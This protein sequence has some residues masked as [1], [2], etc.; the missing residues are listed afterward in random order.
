MNFKAFF[1]FLLCCIFII[2][3]ESEKKDSRSWK[4]GYDTRENVKTLITY[5]I[6]S[7]TL[8]EY[9]KAIHLLKE[10][11]HLYGN[12][13]NLSFEIN[14]AFDEIV[15]TQEVSS[16]VF[17]KLKSKIVKLDNLLLDLD[18]PEEIYEKLKDIKEDLEL[19]EELVVQ[20]EESDFEH[21]LLEAE[22]ADSEESSEPEKNT[23]SSSVVEKET[24]DVKTKLEIT[25]TETEIITESTEEP[26]LLE[27]AEPVPAEESSVP[28]IPPADSEPAPA[29]EP[30]SSE[31]AES[32]PAEE[33][34]VPEMPSADAESA[35]A[36]E[37]ASSEEAESAPAQ[38]EL[39]PADS[40][41][42]VFTGE[43]EEEYSFDQLS[44]EEQ[45]FFLFNM[46]NKVNTIAKQMG[47]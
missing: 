30:A 1:I 24:L 34:S 41:S 29:E 40:E 12:L 5:H 2:G 6:F 18:L 35:P 46:Q 42:S 8:K 39:V 32:A 43:S 13:I 44:K 9:K 17:K 38:T 7:K 25:I 19:I 11:R 10:E 47:Y 28:G 15:K 14:S 33:S 31:E 36:E 27:E 37:P 20:Y 3:C 26:A 22:P 16:E 21:D 4:E 23:E 45:E